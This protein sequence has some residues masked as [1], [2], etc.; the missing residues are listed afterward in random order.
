MTTKNIIILDW[1]DTIFPT[2]IYTSVDST[3]D[4]DSVIE[5][6]SDKDT[7]QKHVIDDIL[8]RTAKLL[9]KLTEIGETIIV[10]NANQEWLNL[11]TSLNTNLDHVICTKKIN[12]ISAR[13]HPINAHVKHA[14]AWKEPVFSEILDNAQHNSDQK[15]CLTVI[16]D[17]MPEFF[18]I[19]CIRDQVRYSSLADIS[20]VDKDSGES[21]ADMI[22][23]PF[24]ELNLHKDSVFK[25]I[26]VPT[27]NTELFKEQ[28]N[29]LITHHEFLIL[30]LNYDFDSFILINDIETNT[31][32]I[33][34]P[35]SL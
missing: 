18:A 31:L 33:P 23:L 28:I 2:T 21:G 1:D 16:G 15:I 8:E 13:D 19:N 34:P 14:H 25:F 20:D 10:S 9:A 24:S 27:K 26:R 6:K 30:S 12:I 7:L 3:T 29:Y 5:S 17:N 4:N 32:Y 11:T 35:L 22:E